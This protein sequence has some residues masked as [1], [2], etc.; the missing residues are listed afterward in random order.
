MRRAIAILAMV[1]AAGGTAGAGTMPLPFR[2]VTDSAALDASMIIIDTRADAD[3]ARPVPSLEG[4][5]TRCL[6]L[7]DVSAANGRLA[8]FRDIF[9]RFGTLGLDGSE[10]LLVIGERTR[11]RD[12]MAALFYLAGQRKVTIWGRPPAALGDHAARRTGRVAEATRTAV[13]SAPMREEAIILRD[14]L[15]RELASGGVLL[16][17]GRSPARY[18]GE[19]AAAGRG[20]HIAGAQSMPVA[21]LRKGA[22][23]IMPENTIPVLYA[24][25]PAEGLAFL[26]TVSGGKGLRARL[27]L[28]GF[29][30]WQAAGLPVEAAA[31]SPRPV[32]PRA[33]SPAGGTGPATGRDAEQGG[34]GTGLG[35]GIG[36][37]ALGFAGGVAATA[38]AF[39]T[40]GRRQA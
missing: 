14:E 19:T 33:A 31:A 10:S 23:L 26:A 21:E 16:L 15:A 40:R 30:D 38:L 12:A 25:G 9:W 3:C 6:S 20:G 37:A 29:S 7:A 17:D 35:T 36:A 11:D 28:E 13:Y 22:P 27:Y 4:G 2:H 5:A 34:P 39:M 8:S 18:W 1:A 32:P 24:A